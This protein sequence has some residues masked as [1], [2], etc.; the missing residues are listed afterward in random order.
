M[1]LGINR[2]NSLQVNS[3][4]SIKNTQSGKYPNLTPLKQDTVNFTGLS[5][6]QEYKDAFEYLAAVILKIKN[7]T[8]GNLSSKKI[9]QAIDDEFKFN[10]VY[11]PYVQADV[12]KIAYKAYVP[13]DV[14]EGGVQLVNEARAAR[15]NE[16]R[17]FLESPEGLE[18]MLKDRKRKYNTKIN[19]FTS[20]LE[21]FLT[22]GDGDGYHYL[23]TVNAHSDIILEFLR[24]AK[25]QQPPNSKALQIV[26]WDA[27]N[28]ELKANNRHIPV[29]FNKDV[30]EKTIDEFSRILPEARQQ[31]FSS[32]SFIDMYTHILRDDVLKRKGIPQDCESVWIKIPSIKH[33]PSN[34]TQNIKDIEILSHK[35]WCTRSSVDK[36]EAALEDGDFYVYLVKDSKNKLWNPVIGMASSEGK[37]AQIQGAN[38][39][40]I[41]PLNYLNAVKQFIEEEGLKCSYNI[42][43]E[44][45]HSGIQIMISEKLREN[46]PEIGQT[47]NQAIKSKDS[48]AIFKYLKQKNLKELEDGTFEIGTYKPIYVYNDKGTTTPYS[49]F[50]I[51]EDKLLENVKRINGDFIL[52][53]SASSAKYR[54][55]KITE[56]P[57]KLEEVTGYVKCT[58]EQYDKFKDDIDRVVSSPKKIKI[59]H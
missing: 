54:N 27:V 16:W 31:R 36:A 10:R 22:N 8:A 48:S 12:S 2:F 58:Q 37:I 56:F 5:R 38:N 43:A 21:K 57:K 39:D 19:S 29:P 33:D 15:L 53:V 18:K 45:P 3:T 1:L 51:D 28:S 34:K 7:K 50:G 23:D 46:N 40:N 42:S 41:I 25:T 24:K 9:S 30:L 35:N 55:S 59:I 49:M 11:G 17:E 4:N 26:I 20:N 47:F 44:Y 6:P 32:I 14:R 52:G 13:Q